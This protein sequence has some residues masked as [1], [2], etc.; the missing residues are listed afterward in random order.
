MEAIG[1]LTGGIA[2]DFNNLL[3]II[4]T[5]PRSS[6][7]SSRPD[8]AELRAGA[9]RAP[10][11]RAAGGELVRKLMAFSRRRSVELQPLN[12]GQVVRTHRAIS[13]VCYRRRSRSRSRWR[14]QATPTTIGDVGAVE[15]MLFNLAT[16]AR[17]A[18][19]DGAR[20]G[21]SRSGLAGRGS[22][23]APAAGAAPGEY[24][25][26]S[27]SDT[28]CGMSPSVQARVFEPFFTTKEVGKGTGL[29]MAMVY[30]LVTQHKGYTDLQSEEGRG[31]TVGFTSRRSTT[32]PAPSGQPSDLRPRWAAPSGFSW[33]TTRRDPALGGPGAYPVRL[34][35]G[36]GRRRRGGHRRHSWRPVSV[37]PGAHRCGDATDGGMALYRELRKAGSRDPCA[38]H[39]RSHRGGPRPT[40]RPAQR[41]PNFSTSPG[42]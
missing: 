7:A 30:G 36:R 35:G 3:T 6:P 18:M 19:P 34:R 14:Q 21:L 29:G 27:V 31:T 41:G 8:R 13:G 33:W 17:D 26:V 28:G 40:G 23:C 11:G 32:S 5:T 4:I 39:E 42:A 12:L 38:A 1:Q 15:Q 37:Q 25:V 2:H 22:I 24:V 10:A 16:N 9:V 20:S